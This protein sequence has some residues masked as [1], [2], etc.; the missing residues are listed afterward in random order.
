MSRTRPPGESPPSRL[1]PWAL[2]PLETAQALRRRLA[3]IIPRRSLY[4]SQGR[5]NT[6]QVLTQSRQN[7]FA[8]FPARHFRAEQLKDQWICCLANFPDG[9]VGSLHRRRKPPRSTN[10]FGSSPTGSQPS[11]AMRSLAKLKTIEKADEKE[12]QRGASSLICKPPR[13]ELLSAHRALDVRA[14]A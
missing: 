5:F 7:E 14:R 10:V 11:S 4:I 6:A 1:A 8:L 12:A 3:A 9:R 13:S 2:P